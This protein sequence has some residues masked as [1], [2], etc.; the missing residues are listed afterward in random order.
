[1]GELMGCEAW[2]WICVLACC[3][4]ELVWVWWETCLLGS[5]LWVCLLLV[6]VS[7][8]WV[9]SFPL[10]SAGRVVFLLVCD[11]VFVGLV[12]IGDGYWAVGGCF[13]VL[14]VV[15][16]YCPFDWLI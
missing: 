11:W 13:F 4:G 12:G 15:C 14:C 3:V 6:A 16:L 1:M 2:V 5:W 9:C 10:C 7:P 8:V